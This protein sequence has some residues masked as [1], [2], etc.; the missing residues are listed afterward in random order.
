[1]KKS[2]FALFGGFALLSVL[3]FWGCKNPTAL[4]PSSLPEPSS[5][6]GLPAGYTAGAISGAGAMQTWTFEVNAIEP[7][8]IQWQ[9][10]H[11]ND[12][13]GYAGCDIKVSAYAYYD[14]KHTSS[15][16]T[17]YPLF[18]NLDSAYTTPFTFKPPDNTY[19]CQHLPNT[20][21]LEV[22]GFNA[23]SDTGSYAIRAYKDSDKAK[24]NLLRSPTSS[25]AASWGW[26]TYTFTAKDLKKSWQLTYDTQTYLQWDDVNDG[27][28]LCTGDITVSVTNS[29]GDVS[30]WTPIV[31]KDWDSAYTLPVC[32]TSNQLSQYNPMTVTVTCKTPG[33]FRIRAW[34][35][36]ATASPVNTLT[37]LP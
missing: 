5:P 15:S 36:N 6:G 31:I 33:T 9:D 23:A 30:D 7:Y 13:S 35:A 19:D 2:Y 21:V 29:H 17:D 11:D 37:P 16:P 25:E 32:F 18:I 14:S 34:N 1:M 8:T 22:T 4:S 27:S 3:N 10:L 28:G 12:G 26:T 24:T 20:V